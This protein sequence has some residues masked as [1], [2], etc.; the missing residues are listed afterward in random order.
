MNNKLD[1]SRPS[2]LSTNKKGQFDNVSNGKSKLNSFANSKQSD[3]LHL[4]AIRNTPFSNKGKTESFVSPKKTAKRLT[5]TTLNNNKSLTP[6][7]FRVKNKANSSMSNKSPVRVL[8]PEDTE[9]TETS[10]IRDLD[11]NLDVISPGIENIKVYVRIR[12]LNVKLQSER[13]PSNKKSIKVLDHRSL[14]VNKE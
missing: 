9:I 7:N 12:P 14:Q 3:I 6:V 4:P 1:K 8:K 11:N 5:N 10:E 2:I 13:D